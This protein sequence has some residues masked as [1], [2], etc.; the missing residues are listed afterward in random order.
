MKSSWFSD[1]FHTF[2]DEAEWVHGVVQRCYLSSQRVFIFLD[3]IYN[4]KGQ[5]S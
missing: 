1:V 4:M 3:I 2:K 5:L